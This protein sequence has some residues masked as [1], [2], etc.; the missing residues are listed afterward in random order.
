MTMI[1]VGPSAVL[2]SS[3]ADTFPY[4]GGLASL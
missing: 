2:W 3:N 4:I 1:A